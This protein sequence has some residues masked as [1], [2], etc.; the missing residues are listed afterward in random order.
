MPLL[1]S[2]L[3]IAGGYH[4]AALAA[5]ALGMDTVQI[6]TKNNNQWRG[7]P[8]TDS[9]CRQF[10]EAL[11]AGNL[12]LPCA[13]NSYLINLA[14]PNDELWNKSID[15]MTVEVERADALGLVGLVAH[16]GSYV[17]SSEEAGLKRIIEGLDVVHDRTKGA[18]VKILVEATAGQGTNLGHRFEHLAAILEGVKDS[19]RLAVC[20]DTCHVF[21][22]GYPLK[23]RGEYEATFQEFDDLIGVERVRAFHLNDSKKPQGSRVDRHE[24]LGEG[25]IGIEPFGW[26]MNDPR[27]AE[28]PMF[29][30]TAKEERDGEPM[31]AVNLRR[32][33]ELMEPKP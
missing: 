30:E 33:R 23:T 22:A 7:K 3:S 29:L 16:P 9:E 31:D 1:G 25:A 18:R 8:L 19:E 24:H 10:Q 2:H 12:H 14:S 13:H 27:F 28:L 11:K 20:L 17:E 4:K 32:L 6:F 26:L 15:A 5:T 21:A